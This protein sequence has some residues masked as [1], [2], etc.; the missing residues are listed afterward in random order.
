MSHPQDPELPAFPYHR[1]PK[2]SGSLRE[3]ST[4]CECCGQTR[5]ILYDGPVYSKDEIDSLCPWCI[6]DGSAAE[7][8]GASFF[9]SDFRDD[10]DKRVSMPPDVHHAVFGCTIGFS[11]FNP[12]GWWVH[13]GKPAAFVKRVE[14]Y[15]LVFECLVCKKQHVIEDYD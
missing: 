14:P 15:D 6:S 3:S 7:R 8:F 10:D 4:P 2:A 13:C 11:T 9:D 12:F 1:D 5:G